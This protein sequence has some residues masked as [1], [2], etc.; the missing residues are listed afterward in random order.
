M[1]LSQ[2]Q[3][4]EIFKYYQKG[5]YNNIEKI[6][7]FG[8][9]HGDL[10]AFKS[11]LRKASLINLQDRWIG[12]NTHVVQVGDI[13]DRKPR[14]EDNSDEDSE[15]IIIGFII[16][17]QIESYVHGGGY[18][19]VIGNHELMNIMGIF[20]YVSNMG[21]RHFKNFE[22]RKNYFRQGGEFC[23]YLAC[24]WNPVI[25]I[26][27]SLFCHGGISKI[28]SHKYNI[29]QINEIMRSRLYNNKLSM[30]DQNFQGLFVGE[31]SILWNRNYSNN[32]AENPRILE[33]IKYVLNR[34]NCKYMIIGHTP[35][36]EGIKVKYN[37]HIICI[38]TAMSQAFGKKR[39]K[40]ER[41]HFIEINKNKVIIK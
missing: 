18:H 3:Y 36:S 41:I 2:N 12:G 13:L 7:A 32:E 37:G 19:P 6:I 38:D 17:L 34:Y 24:G 8:D 22:D 11:C 35:Y 4:N 16:K 28:I 1:D 29:K 5:E 14:S 21:M 33:E 23:K 15:F 39:N 10:Q 26:N 40:L 25:K 30:L 31:N 9:I 20:D 27:N